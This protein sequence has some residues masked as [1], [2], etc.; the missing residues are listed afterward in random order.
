MASLF[1][2]Q[3]SVSQAPDQ[4][5]H[6]LTPTL[7]QAVERREFTVSISSMLGC[8]Y[9]F[10]N[11]RGS[12]ELLEPNRI[13]T[14][15]R[16]LLDLLEVP[17][18]QGMVITA[19]ERANRQLIFTRHECRWENRQVVEVTPILVAHPDQADFMQMIFDCSTTY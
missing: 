7:S 14:T 6:P 18:Y 9:I 10:V 15:I 4:M 3:P 11:H 16:E 5:R 8:D 19:E 12:H 1:T 17:P 2:A 13:Q